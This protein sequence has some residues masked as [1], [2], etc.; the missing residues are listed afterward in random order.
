MEYKTVEA[1]DFIDL[2]PSGS[3]FTSTFYPE[4]Y[5]PVLPASVGT[6]GIYTLTPTVSNTFY[7]D[8]NSTLTSYRSYLTPSVNE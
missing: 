7:S 4:Y 3:M 5:N 2:V 6:S 8:V 1:G